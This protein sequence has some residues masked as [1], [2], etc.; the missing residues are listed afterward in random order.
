MSRESD[1]PKHLDL[2]ARAI[3]LFFATG[4]GLLAYYLYSSGSGFGFWAASFFALA[5]LSVATV[6]PRRFRVGI[7]SSMPWF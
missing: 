2:M 4:F 6:G 5:F 1:I 3:L 7:V